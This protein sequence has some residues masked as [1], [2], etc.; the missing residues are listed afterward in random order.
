MGKIFTL[1]ALLVLQKMGLISF[2]ILFTVL[3]LSFRSNFFN[4]VNHQWFQSHQQ[5]SDDLVIDKLAAE[6][7]GITNSYFL[8]RLTGENRISTQ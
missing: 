2:F 7:L 3:F 8:G 5:D 6:T 1:R 4:I